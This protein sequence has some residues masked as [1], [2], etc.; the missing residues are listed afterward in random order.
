MN[1]QVVSLADEFVIDSDIPKE[2]ETVSRHATLDIIAKEIH[3]LYPELPEPIPD[4]WV[5]N[6]LNK[7]AREARL[8]YREWILIMYVEAQAKKTKQTTLA[9]AGI[10][11]RIG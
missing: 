2:H 11:G 8:Y 4:R 10:I 9:P 3:Y 7:P 6:Q 1:L 5:H